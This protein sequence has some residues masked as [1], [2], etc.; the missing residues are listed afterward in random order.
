MKINANFGVNSAE[1][2]ANILRHV[3]AT[4]SVKVTPDPGMSASQINRSIE[5]SKDPPATVLKYTNMVTKQIELQI[6]SEVSLKLY[7]LNQ[8]FIESQQQIQNSVNIK[9]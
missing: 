2:I 6:P 5:I 8:A 7:R 4:P 3:E 1:M 9:V